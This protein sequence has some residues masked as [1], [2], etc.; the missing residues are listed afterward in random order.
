MPDDFQKK[1]FAIVQKIPKGKVASYG[2]IAAE[3]INARAARMVGWALHQLKPDTKIPWHRVINS[4]GYISTS[5]FEHP[6]NLQK[7]LLEKEG[8]K[9]YSKDGLFYLK[10]PIPWWIGE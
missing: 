9:I 8:I 4:G 10:K 2:M 6:P 7:R 1:V 3:V 5:C